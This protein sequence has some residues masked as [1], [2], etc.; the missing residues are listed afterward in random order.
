M[1]GIASIRLKP[2]F[3][4]STGGEPT[5]PETGVVDVPS[6]IEAEDYVHYKDSSKGNN[7]N[8]YR[9]EDVDIQ[10]TA[11]VGGDTT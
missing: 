8:Q 3:T 10:W 11:D 9:D 7:G 1:N 5:D 6:K 4:R 2:V